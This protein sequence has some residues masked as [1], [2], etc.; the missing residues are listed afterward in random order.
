MNATK[1]EP[2]IRE[3]FE[4][5]EKRRWGRTKEECDKKWLTEAN[6]HL[7]YNDM[8]TIN[9]KEYSKLSLSAQQLCRPYFYKCHKKWRTRYYVRIPKNA[10]RIRYKKAYVTHTKIIDPTMISRMDWIDK[11][12]NSP[13]FYGIQQGMYSYKDYW[14]LPDSKVDRINSKRELAKKEYLNE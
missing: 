14:S 4:V 8:P 11:K 6:K 5:L 3:L 12:L 7:I 13:E 9:K 10:V 2:A 1:I